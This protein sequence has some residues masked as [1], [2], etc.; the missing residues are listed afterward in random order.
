[1]DN[2]RPISK[3]SVLA[4]IFESLVSDQLKDFLIVNNI[5]IP[6]QSGFRKGYS[7]ITA[8]TKVVDDIVSAIDCKESC[9]ALF[10]HLSK[11]FDTV[12]HAILLKRLSKIGMSDNAIERFKNY[13]SSRYQCVTC[14]GIKSG[15]AE[16]MVGVP[17]GSI[18]G[19][20]LFTIYINDICTNVD[21]AAH[22]YA[23]DTIIYS[24]ARS[25]YE[26]LN[27]LQDAFTVL[28]KNLLKLKLV[29]NSK[30]TKFM[31]FTHSRNVQDLPQIITLYNQKIERVSCYNYLGFLLDE[32]LTFNPHVDKLVKKLRVKLRFY[33]GNKACFNLK[34]RKEL[35]AATFL[36]VVDYGDILYM[37]AAK[38]VLRSLDSVYHSALRFVTKAEYFTHH[39]SLYSLS[40]WPPLSI[41]R[42]H[43]WLIFIY[44]AVLG[45]LPSYIL[46]FSFVENNRYNLRSNNSILF[47]TPAVK[48]EFGKIAFRYNAPSTWNAL[49]KQLKISTIIPLN[50]FKLYVAETFS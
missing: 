3:L 21:V 33:Y 20:L 39:C 2:Y 32:K 18:L 49:Q 26:A 42:Q 16:L 30:K 25:P 10:I 9:A 43:H 19:P 48:S 34:A 31:L 47:T 23:D 14:E 37:H 44:K 35:V 1:M 4:K 28:Q 38:S 17:Q 36:S 15:E 6:F 40:G 13:L 12:D 45:L 27:K 11:A 29:L 24:T 8:A 7:T 50:D 22:L 46:V 5:L 41:R